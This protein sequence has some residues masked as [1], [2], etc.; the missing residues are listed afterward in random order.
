M[1]QIDIREGARRQHRSLSLFA[2]IQCWMR[3]L[4][5]IAFQRK[6]LERILGLDR[7]KKTR[8]DWLEEDL[9]EFFPYVEKYWFTNKKNSLGSLIVGRVPF[10]EHLPKGVMT[11]KARI[12]Q[13]S[14][15]APRIGLFEL[16][17]IPSSQE[18]SKSFEGLIP[19]FADSA[20]YDERFLTSYLLLLAQGQISPHNLPPLKPAK[21]ED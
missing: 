3:N 10:S 2:V 18:L 8:V 6:Q 21:D 13:I 5:G 11:T 12:E 19:F 16:W 15:D 7:F 20:N 1:K 4:D 9:K 14:P 17:S